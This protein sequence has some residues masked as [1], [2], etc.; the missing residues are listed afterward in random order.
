MNIEEEGFEFTTYFHFD[1][2][3]RVAGHSSVKN[4]RL[5]A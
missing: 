1:T 5:Q 2:T 4:T 3:V